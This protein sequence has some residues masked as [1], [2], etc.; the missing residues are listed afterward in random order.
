MEGVPL[1]TA[2]LEVVAAGSI[3][4]LMFGF[5]PVLGVFCATTFLS[6]GLVSSASCGSFL[7]FLLTQSLCFL[8]FLLLFFLT[9][10]SPCLCLFFFSTVFFSSIFLCNLSSCCLIDG[11]IV[12]RPSD[13]S[14][15]EGLLISASSGL[16]TEPFLCLSGEGRFSSSETQ[17][18]CAHFKGWGLAMA[19]C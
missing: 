18:S 6:V 5:L 13:P 7:I 3:F 15:E 14:S 17:V 10:F 8:C 4:P 11:G 2:E 16:S 1:C 9:F 19:R 12:T